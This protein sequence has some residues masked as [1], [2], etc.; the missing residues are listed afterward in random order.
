MRL[1]IRMVNFVKIWIENYF[2]DFSENNIREELERFIEGI[3][4][5]KLQAML[6]NH[7]NRKVLS[8]MP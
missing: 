4:E 5:E 8:F 1:S 2:S 7:I 3:E 6:K